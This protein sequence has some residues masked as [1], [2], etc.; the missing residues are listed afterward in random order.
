[1]DMQA[2]LQ[3]TIWANPVNF[4][5][6]TSSSQGDIIWVPIVP[7]NACVLVGIVPSECYHA[8]APHPV[9]CSGLVPTCLDEQDCAIKERS[10]RSTPSTCE[11]SGDE[12]EADDLDAAGE[13]AP[14]G[15][16][17]RTAFLRRQRQRRAKARLAAQQALL[18]AQAP[19]SRWELLIADFEA[20]GEARCEAAA[21]L[22][23]SIRQLSHEPQGCRAVQA[24]L[25]YAG[26]S[27]VAEAVAELR[28]HVREAIESPHANYV[29]Q[30]VVEA[31]PVALSGFVA[32]ELR[33][34]GG[35]MAR[36][37][38]GCRVACRLLEHAALSPETAALVD[39]MLEDAG[40]LSRHT[41]GHHV[42][43]CILEH[44][45]AAQRRRVV[46]AL[47]GELMRCSCN[48]NSSYV[49][50]K[51]L[52]YAS[53]D[54]R[55]A[56]AA[57]LLSSVEGAVILA[58]CQFGSFVARALAR[59]PDEHYGELAFGIIRSEAALVRE[60]KYGQRLL[61]DLGLQSECSA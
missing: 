36:H 9:G 57:E 37:K 60:T 23:G 51:A 56:M 21:S 40:K 26:G 55:V 43:Q 8:F 33:G 58:R 5:E 17:G 7:A 39:E 20:G 15:P 10:G 24:L 12:M 38:F 3:P 61:E 32:L 42:V 49:V 44:G 29:I 59:L 19:R 50:E 47:R 2:P 18:A 46:D 41:F 27:Q 30:K 52:T 53:A 14:Q 1:M 13:P 54:D 6:A 45:Q 48:R 16:Q 22:L 35:E 31:L 28:G 34:S 11:R 4:G 25:Q